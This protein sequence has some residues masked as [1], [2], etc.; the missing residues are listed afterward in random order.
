MYEFGKQDP[1]LENSSEPTVWAF[2][3]LS[4]CAVWKTRSGF[5]YFMSEFLCC[6]ETRSGFRY[7]MSEFLCC[8]EKEIRVSVFHVRVSVLFGKLQRAPG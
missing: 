2:R 8:L 6:L 5:R 7:F 1:G 3:V 4:F